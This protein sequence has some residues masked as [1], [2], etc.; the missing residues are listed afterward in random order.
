MDDSN[1]FSNSLTDVERD[2]YNR[3][4]RLEGW[5]Q[6]LVKKSRVLV[7]GVGG[8]GC[9]TAK[10]LAMV[11]VGRLDLVD[12]DVIEH[13]NLNRQILFAGAEIG[14]PKAEVAAE[15]LLEINPNITIQGYH[16]SLERLDPHVYEAADVI[17]GG[18]DSMNARFNLNTQA[19]TRGKPFVDGGVAGYS[20]HIYSIF[21]G[22]NAC[23]ECYPTPVPPMDD[24]AACT[25]VGIPRKRVHCAFKADMAFKEAFDRDPNLKDINDVTFLQ[26]YANDLATKHDFLPEF[27][28]EDIVKVLDRHDPGIITVNAVIAALESHETIKILHWLRGN[29]SLGEPVMTYVVFNAMTMKFYHIEKRRNPECRQCGDHVRRADLHIPWNVPCKTI[30]TSLQG[31]GYNLDPELE[32]VVT[33]MDFDMVREIELDLTPKQN[34]LRDK[35]FL[36]VAGFK[37]GEIFIILNTI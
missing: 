29:V 20:G 13:S 1:F 36:T 28:L 33:V 14:R 25:V 21:P 30:I 8:L 26:K 37:E 27:T 6:N 32:P 2:L 7:A 23:Y 12:L 35:D 3:Q 22:K 15:K 24:M 17:V 5:D 18:L 4:F 34:D 10:N 11:G 19:V 16:T 9:E 31:N